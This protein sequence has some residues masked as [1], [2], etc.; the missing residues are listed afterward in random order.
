MNPTIQS[1]THPDAE[2]LTAFAEQLLSSA[3]RE[4]ILAHM[5]VCSRCREVVFL[6]QQAAEGE[7][8]VEAVVQQDVHPPV[9]RRWFGGW[10]WAWVPVAAL[11]GFVG[12][13]VVQHE[14]H[15]LST[16][17]QQVAQNTP[18]TV[19]VRN[20]AAAKSEESLAPAQQQTVPKEYLRNELA[21]A[22]KKENQPGLRDDRALDEKKTV[23]NAQKDVE[24]AGGSFG[25][26]GSQG[27]TARAVHGMIAARA[28]SPSMGGPAALNQ[29][30]QQNMNQLQQQN[31]ALQAQPMN[32]ALKAQSANTTLHLD[33]VR[34]ASNPAYLANKPAPPPPG[35]M[36]ETVSVQAE[37]VVPTS[38]AA[39]SVP[40]QQI[41]SAAAEERSLG[42]A[43]HQLSKR[44]GEKVVLPGGAEAL[45]SASADTRTIAIDT[46]GN[47]FVS[48][49]TGKHWQAVKT[50]WTGR[51]VLVK[52]QQTG[53]HGA[54]LSLNQK[55]QFELVTDKLETWS[56]PDG[57]IWILE[58]PTSK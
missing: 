23:A 21:A 28:K 36:N 56:S 38:S 49:D 39:A 14:R 53:I 18:E 58:P 32:D 29:F 42:L 46:T 24:A 27:L 57:T 6:A 37:P 17:Q 25:V 40:V 35:S 15:T 22:R 33:A 2:S 30:Q 41:A 48:L 7:Q 5:A 10:R 13:A 12:V 34:Q 43:S 51:A 26:A 9:V 54:V 55:P 44:K 4:Q 16:K 31:N 8:P 47:L 45:S 1:G 20:A 50:Q 11:A 52:T 19:P 3:E